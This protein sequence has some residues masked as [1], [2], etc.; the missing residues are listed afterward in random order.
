VRKRKES[1]KRGLNKSQI[2]NQV[3]KVFQN[4]IPQNQKNSHFPVIHATLKMKK[5]NPINS[6]KRILNREE[7]YRIL[8]TKKREEKSK[9]KMKEQNLDSFLQ[10]NNKRKKEVQR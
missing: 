6:E 10:L 5:K 7:K 4:L 9:S 2:A 1:K 3:Y 8:L